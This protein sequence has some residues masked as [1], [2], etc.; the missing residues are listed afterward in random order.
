MKKVKLP[1]V[2]GKITL[3]DCISVGSDEWYEWLE[4]NKSFN[5][6]PIQT[7]RFSLVSSITVRNRSA[8]YWYAYRK[9]NKKQRQVYLGKTADL[10]YEKLQDAAI[11]LSLNDTEYYKLLANRKRVVQE[12]KKAKK[13]Q[14]VQPCLITTEVV[15]DYFDSMYTSQQATELAA[16][17]EALTEANQ[18]LKAER[19]ELLQWKERAIPHIEKYKELKVEVVEL[20][21]RLEESTDL[22]ASQKLRELEDT[23][24][25]IAVKVD[26]ET[27]SYKKNSCAT[28]RNRILILA[29]L[30]PKS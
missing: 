4:T 18:H 3:D 8:N 1:V 19:D 29:G 22:T 26:M 25:D 15:Q 20:R 21:A 23:I 28:L 24:R 12:K 11:E 16:E 5:Y 7:E 17:V 13:N 10:T 6:E 30:P 14:V 9:V 27:S 2:E